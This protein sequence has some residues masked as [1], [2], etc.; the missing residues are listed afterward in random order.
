MQNPAYVL[1]GATASVAR[2]SEERIAS[3]AAWREAPS[4]S[5]AERAVL[6]LAESVTRLADRSQESVPDALWGEVAEHFG[7]KELPALILTVA[8]TDFF[9]RINTTIRE[10]SGTSWG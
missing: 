7:E 6:Q 10:H 2:T 5:D 9:N 8:L 3:V 1:P 4:F